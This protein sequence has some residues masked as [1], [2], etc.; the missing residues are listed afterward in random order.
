MSAAYK[1]FAAVW[2]LLLMLLA[3][4]PAAASAG[5]VTTAEG[6]KYTTESGKTVTGLKK[7]GKR[8]YLFAKNGIMLT[9]IQKVGAKYYFFDVNPAP[10]GTGG[11]VITGQNITRTRRPERSTSTSQRESIISDRT[12]SM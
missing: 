4:R 2:I 11:S 5:F 1:R 6:V 3:I 10:A 12:V 7:I 8:T 9:G